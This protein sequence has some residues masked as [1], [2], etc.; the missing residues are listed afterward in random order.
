MATGG[1]IAQSTHTTVKVA[2][3]L[4]GETTDPHTKLLRVSLLVQEARSYWEHWSADIPQAERHTVAFE[5][6]WFGS[7]TMKRVRV[8]LLALQ[9]RFDAFPAALELLAKWR[10]SDPAVRQ[11]ICHWHTQLSDPIYRAFSGQFL[12]M[13]RQR[14]DRT[15]DRDATVRWVRE[16]TGDKWAAATANRMANG[17]LSTASEAGLC[18]SNP[19]KREILFP[20][21]PDEALGY[22]MYL[23]RGVSFQGS[24]LDNPY[25]ASVALTEG[26]L[27]QRLSRLPSMRFARQGELHDFGW[28]YPDLGAWAAGEG[29]TSHRSEA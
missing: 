26:F 16:F 23:L 5:Q 25:I 6:R 13:R 12:D 1:N 22:L 9:S 27:D 10:P 8:V 19:G 3:S 29:L 17:L 11:L 14:P 28:T 4:G 2:D 20:T 7:K 21:V 18:S 24:L 15:V